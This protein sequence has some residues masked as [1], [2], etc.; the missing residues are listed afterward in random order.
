MRA[1]ILA[2]DDEPQ[3]EALLRQR[4]RR[5][6]REGRF[7]FIFAD[8]GY[9]A[10]QIVEK[11]REIDMV[12]TDINMPKMDGLSFINELKSV[13][14]LLKTVI[15]SAYGDMNNIRK[16]MN[17][18]AFDFV[19]KP[20]EFVDLE[21]TI[22]KTLQEMKMLKQAEKARELSETNEKLKELDALKSN[23]FANISHEFRTPLTVIS[24]MTDQ[25]EKAPDKWVDKGV[26]MIRRNTDSLLEMV[27]QILELRKLESGKMSLKLERGEVLHFISYLVESFQSLA[28]SRNIELQLQ[29]DISRLIMD[30]DPE[31]L[32]RILYNLLG[33]A[34]KF[35][36][37][38]GQVFLIVN[39]DEEHLFL[40]VKDTGVGMKEEHMSRIFDRY[41]SLEA[42]DAR[43]DMGTGIGLSLVKELVKLMAGEIQVDSREGSGTT[44]LV[45]LPLRTD[46]VVDFDPETPQ[47][48]ASPLRPAVKGLTPTAPMVSSAAGEEADSDLPQLLIVEDNLDVAQYLVAC[49]EDRYQLFLAADGR[50]GINLAIEKVPDIIIS[51]VMMPEKNG[52]ELCDTLKK[53]ERTS[54]IPIILLTAKADIESKISGLEK[55]A[56]AYLAKPFNRDE[57]YVRLNKLLE[58]RR[59]LQEKYSNLEEQPTPVSLEDEFITRVRSE[60]EQN[61]DDE[62]F[63]IPELCQ[64][65]GMSR[66]QLHR[67]LKALTGK[68][69]SHY[70]RS[71]RLYHARN[72]LLNSDLNIAQVA[73]E[74]GFSDPKYFSR[75][76]NEEYG[77]TPK[78]FRE[79]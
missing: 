1:R 79:Q 71:I 12:L 9:N 28:E 24:G 35:T 17:L 72:I 69:T 42:V 56:D 37:P 20:I 54:H 76:F 36:P 6:I 38:G 5:Q 49:L 41:F 4:F 62:F 7:E 77:I 50:E 65:I 63:G 27:N 10:L 46:G 21:T 16:A 68:S 47:Q 29:T 34:I 40:Q 2:V 23:F 45:K 18:G 73:F 66:A 43:K 30:Y 78:A 22:D 64:S 57:L 19:T 61:L 33:N 75:V 67:K 13:R 31:K 60:I 55:G 15:V 14:P 32:Q 74:V 53:D 59:K 52:Y 25:I 44:F 11:D 26:K 70:V 39:S 51:D 3:F 58:L 8:N 48:A